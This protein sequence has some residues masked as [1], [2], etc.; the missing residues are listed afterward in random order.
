MTF[1]EDDLGRKKKIAL[2]LMGLKCFKCGKSMGALCIPAD[3]PQT[4]ETLGSFLVHE[5]ILPE[6]MSCIGKNPFVV[7]FDEL[8]DGR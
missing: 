6:C 5:R 3:H 2:Q 1:R 4:P 8:R 7:G